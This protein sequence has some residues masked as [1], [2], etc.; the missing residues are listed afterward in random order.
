MKRY[1]LILPI[2]ITLAIFFYPIT[3][4]S[5]STGSVG[6]KTGSPTDGASCTACHY[7]GV[8]TGATIT[9]NIPS[10]GYIPNQVYT[11]TGNI[12][13]MGIFKF[14]FEISAEEANFGSAKTGSFMVTNSSE[15]QFVN[16]NEAITHTAGGT[17]GFNSKSWSMDWEAPNSGTGSITFYGAFLGTNGDGS[18]SGDTYHHATLT[19][20][21][22]NIINSENNI[23]SENQIVF[24]S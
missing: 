8:G 6:G 9:T 24:N 12:Q 18:N 20:N 16:N 1:L 13:E 11:I 19:I 4:N 15:T 10:S 17:S 14:G 22:A 21:E 5:N 7:A 3:S 23:S 2:T